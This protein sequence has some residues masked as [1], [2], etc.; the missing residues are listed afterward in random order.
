MVRLSLFV[1]DASGLA[2]FVSLLVPCHLRG[3]LI[4]PKGENQKRLMKRTG[5]F[6]YVVD[7]KRVVSIPFRSAFAGLIQVAA[8]GPE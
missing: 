3:R 7:G 4:G 8:Q 1:G 2:P 6:L 5:A